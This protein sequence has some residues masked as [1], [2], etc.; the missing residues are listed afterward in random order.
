MPFAGE[1]QLIFLPVLPFMPA[2]KKSSSALV[3]IQPHSTDAERT[4][5]GALLLDPEAIFRIADKLQSAD[6]YDPVYRA[7][8]EAIGTLMTEGT[9]VDFVTVCDRLRGCRPVER[10]GGSA[11]V[12]EL[13]AGV[14]TSSHVEQ[15]A[16]I[17]LE[18]SRRRQLL[19]LGREVEQLAVEEGH[20]ASD[21]IEKAEQEFL[22]LSQSSTSHAPTMLADMRSE[23][24]DHYVELYEADDPTEHIGTR[25]GFP[26]LDHIL[27]AMAPGQ[28]IVLAGRPSMGKTALALDIARNVGLDQKKPVAIFS[29]EMSK[30]EIFDRIFGSVSA[31]EPWRLSKGAVNEEEFLK[32]GPALDRLAEA[33][34]VID[35][36]SDR[37]LT[38]IRSKARRLQMQ[39]PL[40]LVIV[41]Y[42]QQIDARSRR[43]DENQTQ[44]MSVVSESLKQLARELQ[45]PVLALC[46]LNRKC[47]ERTDKRPQLSDLRDSG[48]IEQDAD[49]V[50][51]LYRDGYYDEDTADLT[52]TDVY[53]RKN[54]HGPTGH[55]ELRFNNTSMEFST[56]TS[57]RPPCPVIEPG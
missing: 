4:V 46:Q 26:D 50:L 25:T 18:K 27:T 13:A 45:C 34:I 39:Q 14:P 36:D 52:L 24:Y 19:K 43:A 5:L 44:R 9:P 48:S 32:M 49:R 12:A 54:R 1:V 57:P 30:E 17:V 23:R 37:S 40:S 38:A 8:F 10:S 7:I 28:L 42:M 29:L 15:Y 2:V 35:D 20:T 51:M 22:K 6:F 56:T 33:R 11:F 41:D 53:I 31:I 16:D 47:E 21:L 55:V 3:D